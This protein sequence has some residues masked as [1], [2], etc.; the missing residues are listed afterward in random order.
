[1]DDLL[2]LLWH[3]QIHEQARQHNAPMSWKKAQLADSVTWCGWTLTC[4]SKVWLACTKLQKL[5]MQ[6][7]ALLKHPSVHAKAWR[8]AWADVE[9]TLSTCGPRSHRSIGTCTA[10]KALL[11][12]TAPRLWP[13]F[14][15]ALD[16]SAKGRRLP[17]CG[18][19]GRSRI[20]AVGVQ[21]CL[22]SR[23]PRGASL[24]SPLT[25]ASRTPACVPLLLSPARVMLDLG[26]EAKKVRTNQ[27]LGCG[28]VPSPLS[29]DFINAEKK[30]SGV[31]CLVSGSV[32]CLSCGG[33]FQAECT[34][35]CVACSW[36]EPWRAPRASAAGTARSLRSVL[37]AVW[38][39]CR[40]Q[41][42]CFCA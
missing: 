27:G 6:M 41:L 16:A 33:L 35:A 37:A 18:C 17:A 25:S 7:Q 19:N 29:V 5:R 10:G 15:H 28:K 24:T 32:P 3:A 4:K 40:R 21:C 34:T 22:Q 30:E 20:T 36:Q 31:L 8:H 1:M 14:L 12:S 26:S 38:E 39:G 9:T 11:K 13:Q 23:H 2:N 42:V